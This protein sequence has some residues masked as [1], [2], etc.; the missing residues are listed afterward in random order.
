MSKAP[1]TDKDWQLNL[2]D[3]MNSANPIEACTRA[4]FLKKIHFHLVLVRSGI[5]K[6]FKESILCPGAKPKDPKV[7]V[8][9]SA[10]ILTQIF[11]MALINNCPEPVESKFFLFNTTLQIVYRT[12]YISTVHWDKY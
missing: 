3:I 5:P 2:K 7:K 12:E 8:A 11:Q 4:T 6:M 9:L 10:V 1:A